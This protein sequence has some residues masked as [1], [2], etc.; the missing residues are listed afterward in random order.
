MIQIDSDKDY[1]N[2]CAIT[3]SNKL[4]NIP[5]QVLRKPLSREHQETLNDN[6]ICIVSNYKFLETK[7]DWSPKIKHICHPFRD[8]SIFPA[9]KNLSLLS[10]SDFIDKLWV[11]VE[12]KK[13]AKEI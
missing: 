2:L 6:S 10:E 3:G 5:N 12:K 13:K 4:V 7:I 9:D 8:T 11:R 1:I